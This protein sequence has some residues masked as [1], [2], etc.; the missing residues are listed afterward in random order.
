MPNKCPKCKAVLQSEDFIC[1]EC[2]H[3]LGDP[4]HRVLAPRPNHARRQH[5]TRLSF[6]CLAVSILLFVISV[7]LVCFGR[8]GNIFQ[9]PEDVGYTVRVLTQDSDPV[10]GAVIQLLDAEAQPIQEQTTDDNGCVAFVVSSDIHVSA[11]IKSVPQDDASSY[12]PEFGIYAFK[13][14]R[15][16][17]IDLWYNGYTYA[18][19]K[20]EDLFTVV[21][22][23]QYLRPVEGVGLLLS[24]NSNLDS[25]FSGYTDQDGSYR[26]CKITHGSGY[27]DH[28]Q[29]ISVPEG[30]FLSSSTIY[31][32]PENRN[33]LY[34]RVQK[35]DSLII[36]PP[37]VYAT[38]ITVKDQF[39]E[40]VSGVIVRMGATVTSGD[41]MTTDSNGKIIHNDTI[42][43]Q[44]YVWIVSVPE[45]YT[46]ETSKVYS[47]QSGGYVHITIQRIDGG[48][49]PA[50]E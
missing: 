31:T 32:L 13:E 7:L 39:G 50:T 24:S 27:I 15:T 33:V 30:Y 38:I 18:P 17:Q 21:V 6:I 8:Q 3:I 2:G 43:K 35:S 16:L 4:V 44:Y 41:R 12:T 40:P 22:L 34:V 49:M 45:G 5:S 23:D 1:P 9:R 19:Y 11:T 20:P 26:F 28:V 36:W 25:G 47:V 29:I 14:D 10:V 42:K 37:T 48:V 46:F